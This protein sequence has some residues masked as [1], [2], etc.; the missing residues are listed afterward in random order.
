MKL[1][2]RT[3]V[4][5]GAAVAATGTLSV[6][7]IAGGRPVLVVYDSRLLESAAFARAAG[8]VQI[9]VA[10]EDANFWRGLRARL[11]AGRVIGLTR[12]PDFVV[13]RGW[14]EEQGKRLKLEERVA[15]GGLFRWELV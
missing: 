12:W 1:T 8:A 10:A 3:L 2:R 9:D 6:R 13:A 4:K 11:P 5:T 14:L 7:A 15:P